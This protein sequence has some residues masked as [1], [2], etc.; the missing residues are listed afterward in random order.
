MR[1]S[2]PHTLGRAEAVGRIR[3][4]QHEIADLVPGFAKVRTEWSGD[5]RLDLRVEVMGK[6]IHGA[7][8]VADAS[9]SFDFDIPAALAFAEPMIR[10]AIEPR[11]QKLLA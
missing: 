2:V 10:A 4:R 7:I 1:L 9:V 11:A 3:A 8:E 5:D 6:T